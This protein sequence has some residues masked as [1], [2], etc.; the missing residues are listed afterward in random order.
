MRRCCCSFGPTNGIYLPPKVIRL[1]G[2]SAVEEIDVGKKDMPNFFV[3]ALTVA[4]AKVYTDVRE[5]IVPPED[6]DL[7]CRRVTADAAE[8]KPGEQRRS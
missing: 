8:Y 5:V 6:R 4:N 2:K 7:E 3:E 1:K